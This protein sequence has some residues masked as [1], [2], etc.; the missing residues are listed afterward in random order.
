MFVKILNIRT[1]TLGQEVQTQI[2]LSERSSLIKVS[3]VSYSI[4][5]TCHGRASLFEFRLFTSLLEGVQNLRSKT[6]YTIF[7]KA[8]SYWLKHVPN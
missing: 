2:R 3:T 6:L 4:C 7:K 5:I 1:D 8:A